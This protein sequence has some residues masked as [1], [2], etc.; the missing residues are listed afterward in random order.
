MKNKKTNSM[1]KQDIKERSKK[2]KKD[3]VRENPSSHPGDATALPPVPGVDS[4]PAHHARGGADPLV[5][6]GS[7]L[8]P[9]Q[10]D[11]SNNFSL[12]EILSGRTG[13]AGEENDDDDSEAAMSDGA[14]GGG[15]D[16]G[17]ALQPLP[18]STSIAALHAKL[19][20]RIASL[21]GKRF[22]KPVDAG[23]PNRSLAAAS[24]SAT[25]GA[26]AVPPEP[27]SKEELLA[28]ARKRR[29]ELRDNR[30]NARKEE[31]RKEAAGKA[32]PAAAT[33]AGDKKKKAAE[34]ELS[35]RPG[36]VRSAPPPSP[37]PHG[38]RQADTPQ[39]MGALPDR[40]SD[41]APRARAQDGRARRQR[42]LLAVQAALD[43]W[44][45][46]LDLRQALQAAA[47]ESD[48]GAVGPRSAEGQAGRAAG[49]GPDREGRAGP[50]VQGARAG[51][52]R[53][54]PGRCRPA[55]EGGQAQGEGEGKE[56]DR[57]V[58]PFG[59]ACGLGARTH[60]RTHARIRALP[61]LSL[62]S[63]EQGILT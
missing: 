39:R 11:P 60:A 43:L 58:R 1:P 9:H 16:S 32:K 63:T 38:G 19:Q 21:Q 18:P 47:L 54:G 14:G 42:L 7:D 4:L 28:E 52:G 13:R 46:N 51:R 2:A 20:E 62:P 37:P 17:A 31:R 29:G 25:A 10:L 40:P 41:D 33:A 53:Q 6:T 49:R 35:V 61:T 56:F 36:K 12:P 24:S 48:P 5:S 45:L 44:R 15:A 59:V 34:G 22:D 50:L 3:K 23:Y 26:G 30:R 55:Q 27:G 57:M 8:P